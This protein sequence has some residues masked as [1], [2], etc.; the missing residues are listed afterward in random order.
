MGTN[1]NCGIGLISKSVGPKIDGVVGADGGFWGGTT[2]SL[3][4]SSC[5]ILETKCWHKRKNRSNSI[6]HRNDIRMTKPE[7]L[8]WLCPANLRIWYQFLPPA[9]FN[10]RCGSM[11][12]GLM[13]T[14]GQ[15]NCQKHL[16]LSKHT[17]MII[18]WKALEEHFLMVPLSIF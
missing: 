7:T 1:L 6:K 8:T 17:N 18:H 5:G 11:G 16:W 14:A 4:S 12:P 15:R 13:V 10:T 3:C 2:T 9:L